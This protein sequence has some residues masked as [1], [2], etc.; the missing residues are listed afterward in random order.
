MTQPQASP[1]PAPPEI[2]LEIRV[3]GTASLATLAA[4]VEK[5][6]PLLAAAAELGEV[7]LAIAKIGKQRWP[8]A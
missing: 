2:I 4:I 8:I 3:K 6:K 7:E 1:P 5:S